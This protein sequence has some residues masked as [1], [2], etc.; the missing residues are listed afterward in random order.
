M[1][2]RPMNWR[3][4]RAPRGGRRLRVRE[5]SLRQEARTRRAALRCIDALAAA[6]LYA[7][8]KLQQQIPR[9]DE[10]SLCARLT[11]GGKYP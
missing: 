7:L 1:T 10:A 3:R 5:R 4:L 6:L 9:R 8:K 2:W 11:S